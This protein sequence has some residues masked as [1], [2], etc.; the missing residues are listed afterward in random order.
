MSNVLDIG[1]E[2]ILEIIRTSNPKL[3]FDLF[4]VRT[5]VWKYPIINDEFISYGL[6][7]DISKLDSIQAF[8]LIST[9]VEIVISQT[10]DDLFT[11]ALSLLLI[12]AETTN[13]TEIPCELL[14][15]LTSISK[16]VKECNVKDCIEIWNEIMNWYRV[17]NKYDLK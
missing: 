8:N 2:I 9:A 12:C 3:L 4:N 16:K 17:D 15:N 11:T 10:D 7:S 5:K 1:K 14:K 6:F 13:T